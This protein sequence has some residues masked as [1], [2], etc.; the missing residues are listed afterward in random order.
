MNGSA[1]SRANSIE[2]RH[3]ENSGNRHPG[4][5]RRPSR[6]EEGQGTPEP[7]KNKG[8][9]P[10]KYAPV[11]AKIAEQMCKLGATDA[12]L[13]AAFGVTTPTIW[14]WQCRYDEFF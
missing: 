11:F 6:Q 14:N 4:R 3:D 10:T 13:A 12:D 5:W 8:G 7:K 9:R 1:A 2:E